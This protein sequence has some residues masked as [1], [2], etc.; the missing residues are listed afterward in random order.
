MWPH[1][2]HL[3]KGS[4][5]GASN[6]GI[7]LPI[8][9][10]IHPLLVEIC[11]LFVTW[12]NKITMLTT[13]SILIVKRKNTL[14]KTSYEHVPTRKKRVEWITTKQENSVTNTK[15]VYFEKKCPQKKTYANPCARLS[16][17]ICSC[18]RLAHI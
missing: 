12:S 15:M 5:L 8:V 16:K 7:T 1:V 6:T 18:S 3:I 2:G 17:R 14:S 11:I 13:I 10:S 9:V 4:C